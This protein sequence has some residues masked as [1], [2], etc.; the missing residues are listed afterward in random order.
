MAVGEP[1]LPFPARSEIVPATAFR[2]TWVVSSI[3]SLRARGHFEAYVRELPDRFRGQILESVVGLWLPMDAARAHY[4]AC[5]RLGLSVDE[6]LAMGSAVGERAQG[7]LLS[8]V[9][10]TAKGAGVTPWTV[11]PQFDRLWRR[12]AN[13]GA[14]AVY[15]LG[16]KEARTEFVGCVL[17]DIPYFR[18]AFRGV[19]HGI[20]GLFCE[21]VYVHEL[22]KR[23]PHGAQF[24]FQWA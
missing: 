11:L 12:G 5:E 17:F 4:E 9:V 20:A 21:K 13:G 22:P 8:T 24:R 16:P 7:T 10:K 6:Q 18:H 14:V 19:V 23:V 3:Q 2:T 15:R 1:V